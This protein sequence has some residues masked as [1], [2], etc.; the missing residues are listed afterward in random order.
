MTYA[1]AQ[2]GTAQQMATALDFES[3]T[4]IDDAREIEKTSPI[5]DPSGPENGGVH[6]GVGQSWGNEPG[7]GAARDPVDMALA[8]A[9]TEASAA[10]RFDVVA[11]LAKELEA[12]RL[13]R[14]PNVVA[15]GRDWRGKGGS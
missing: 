13:A 3:S 14:H 11:Q 15:L 9:L 12:R 8:R 2:N 5:G 1:G 7:E 6:P 4:G 10:G